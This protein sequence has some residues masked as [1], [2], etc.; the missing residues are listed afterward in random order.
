MGNHMQTCVALEL[1]HQHDW[2]TI[3]LNRPASRNALSAQMVAEL[4]HVLETIAQDRATR[5]VTLRGR[6]GV[7]CAGGDL[8]SFKA[9]MQG[10]A[11]DAAAVAASNREGGR[12]FERINTL[13][14]VVVAVVEGAA[15]AGGLG[16]VCC[17]D[18]VVVSADAQ[19]ALTETTLGIPPAQ[20]APFVAD[21]LGLRIA[22]RLMLT[23]ARFR[24]S[25]AL[26][27]GLADYVAIDANA[28]AEVEA[29]IRQ[30]VR[31]CAPVA[32]AVT[33]EILL[34]SRRLDRETML[35]F[36]ATRFA[37]CLLGDE[38]REGITAFLDKRPA[39][40]SN[41]DVKAAS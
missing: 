18:V 16:M 26:Q 1:E 35:D 7:F 34:A 37:E 20:I 23:A 33:K 39:A 25:E 4:L 6:G 19:F 22:R 30:Q 2:I 28:L 3:W 36:A 24:G 11:P 31:R 29:G 41:A 38:G 12:L 14:Q 9:S 27:L 8:A 5:G 21:R 32:N 40:W 13:P 15:M 17:A 10:P